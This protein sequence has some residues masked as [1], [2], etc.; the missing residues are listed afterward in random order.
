MP[1][2]PYLTAAQVRERVARSGSSS[3]LGSTTDDEIESLVAEFEEIAED[4]LGNAWVPRTTTEVVEVTEPTAVLW[5]TW[6]LVRSVTSLTINGTAVASGNYTPVKSQGLI[7]LASAAA[8][9][10]YPATVVYVHGKDAPTNTLLRACALYVQ[11]VAEAD[12]SGQG[13]DLIA[14][15]IDGGTTR[16]STPDKTAGRPTGWLEV[17][18]LLNA[19]PKSQPVVF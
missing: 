15:G 3:P 19:V 16:Y 9:P 11:R 1:S 8:T 5:L 2:D 13:R 12:K 10:D 14:Q 6:P 4:Y 7:R 18:R 17:D